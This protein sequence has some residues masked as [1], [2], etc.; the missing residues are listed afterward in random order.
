[1]PDLQEKMLNINECLTMMGAL[2]EQTQKMI[3]NVNDVEI[4]R[5]NREVRYNL[6]LIKRGSDAILAQL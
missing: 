5:N 6:D 2:V 4:V 3:F 1:M